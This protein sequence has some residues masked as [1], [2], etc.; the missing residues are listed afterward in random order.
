MLYEV[1]TLYAEDL[2]ATKNELEI[3]GLVFKGFDGSENC[4]TF[5]DPDGNW[6]QLV[7]PNE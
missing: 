2:P 5:T 6:F 4:L 1:I 3:K 7:N